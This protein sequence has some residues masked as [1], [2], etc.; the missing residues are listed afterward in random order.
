MTSAAVSH[1]P[2]VTHTPLLFL[3]REVA[4]LTFEMGDALNFF[5]QILK[6]NISEPLLPC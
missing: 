1:Q 6:S 3:C 2:S 5:A 4:L